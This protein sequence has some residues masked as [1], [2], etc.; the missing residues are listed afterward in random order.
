MKNYL[1]M[2]YFILNLIFIDM[3]EIYFQEFIYLNNSLELHM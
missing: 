1:Y 2:K 3:E